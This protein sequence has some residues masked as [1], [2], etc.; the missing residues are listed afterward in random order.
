VKAPFSA[1]TQSKFFHSAFNS[2]I[3]DGPVRIYFIQF[4]ESFALKIYFALQ[5]ELS[6]LFNTVKDYSRNAGVTV[7]IMVYPNDEVFLNSFPDLEGQDIHN[8]IGVDEWEGESVIGVVAEHS[9]KLIKQITL[10]VK[11]AFQ[12]WTLMR[13]A[14]LDFENSNDKTYSVIDEAGK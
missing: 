3:F 9:D 2:A 10:E 13:V 1:L 7:L 12:N 8:T 5:D 14:K 11:K 6:P 4:H